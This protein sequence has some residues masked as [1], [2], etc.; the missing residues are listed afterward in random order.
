M[1]YFPLQR[2]TRY[3]GEGVAATPYAKGSL[4]NAEALNKYGNP[5]TQQGLQNLYAMLQQQGR[6][7]PRLLATAQAQ[8]ARATQQQQ[9]AARAGAARRGIGGGGLS[10]ALQAAIGAAGSNRASGLNYQDIS[11]SYKRN[12]ENLGLL[13]QLVTQ[14]QLGYASISSD[15]YR[16]KS[17]ADTQT[18]AA[19]L[20]VIGSVFQG[21]GGMFGCWVAE[22]IFGKDAIETALARIYVNAMA[23]QDLYEAYMEHGQELAAIVADDDGLKATLRPRFM[24]F[25]G[26]AL[27]ALGG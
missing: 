2:P 14:P 22:A 10:D 26:I 7:D 24:E 19:R 27:T 1:G 11:D 18:K 20:G 3:S 15:L 23:Q 16:T 5:A 8:N 25:G 21:I 12:Q 13:N 17:D 9:D 4:A 6:V